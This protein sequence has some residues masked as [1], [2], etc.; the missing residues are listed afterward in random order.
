MSDDLQAAG[1]RLLAKIG[2]YLASGIIAV[3]GGVGTHKVEDA[4]HEKTVENSRERVLDLDSRLEQARSGFRQLAERLTAEESEARA[5]E[6]R[7]LRAQIAA[8]QAEI[9]D[10]RASRRR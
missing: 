2:P 3:A 4:E 10:L 1:M 5:I 6:I 7:R 9:D 8:L